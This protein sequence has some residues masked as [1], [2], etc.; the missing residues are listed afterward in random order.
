MSAQTVIFSG[1]KACGL[2]HWTKA[3]KAQGVQRCKVLM[4]DDGATD[5]NRHEYLVESNGTYYG[6][7]R[8]GAGMVTGE[9]K[10]RE[11][12]CDEAEIWMFDAA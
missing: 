3:L 2:V 1:I 4:A 8:D 10:V 7:F 6:C 11:V 5:L 12:S 9:E